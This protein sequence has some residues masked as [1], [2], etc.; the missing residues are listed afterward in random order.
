MDRR[1]VRCEFERRFTADRMAQEYIN[2]YEVV[3]GN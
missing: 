2:L 3:C 1:R